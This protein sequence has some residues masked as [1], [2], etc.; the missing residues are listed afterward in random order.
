MKITDIL[1]F[2]TGVTAILGFIYFI[3]GLFTGKINDKIMQKQYIYVHLISIL[4]LIVA[5]LVSLIGILL[6][7]TDIPLKLELHTKKDTLLLASIF[8]EA[9]PIWDI[10]L[11]GRMYSNLL[12]Q[13]NKN[14]NVLKDL[15]NWKWGAIMTILIQ[16]SL[17][18]YYKGIYAFLLGTIRL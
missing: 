6:C 9:L 18:N 8:C 10:Y 7:S 12:R 16:L 15:G 13:K 5:L 1:A 4:I 11:V 3:V 2:M 17:I 14:L